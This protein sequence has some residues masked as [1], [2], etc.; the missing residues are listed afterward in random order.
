MRL[1]DKKVG[2]RKGYTRAMCH[3]AAGSRLNNEQLNIHLCTLYVLP[4]SALFYANGVG[5]NLISTSSF[6]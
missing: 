3:R 2:R 6:A 1:P 4:T 5:A